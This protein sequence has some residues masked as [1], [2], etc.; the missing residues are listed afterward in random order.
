MRLIPLWNAVFGLKRAHVHTFAS[1][2]SAGSPSFYEQMFAPH[3]TSKLAQRTLSALR[4]T[5][6]FLLLEDDY[7]VDWEVDHDEPLT[8]MHPHRASLRG[9]GRRS[10]RTPGRRAGEAMP[11]SSICRSPIGGPPTRGPLLHGPARLGGRARR[12]AWSHRLRRYPSDA[13]PAA[14]VPQRT[15]QPT[16]TSRSPAEPTGTRVSPA[17]VAVRTRRHH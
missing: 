10:R 16:A 5:R 17:S 13:A 14:S 8:Q 6:S 12:R 9:P 3:S 11:T 15:A 2:P 1:D 4:L 7:D